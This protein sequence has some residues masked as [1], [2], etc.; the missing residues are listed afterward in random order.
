MVLDGVDPEVTSQRRSRAPRRLRRAELPT[1]TVALARYLIGKTLVEAGPEGRVSGRI[2]ET[3]AY[4]VGDAACHAFRGVTPR[5]RSLFLAR[6]H[7]YVY[8]I[9]GV[10]FMLNVSSETAGVGAGVLLR[11]VEPL[12]GAA[13]M[14]T[15]RRLPAATT[16]PRDLARGPGRL[17]QAFAI[18]R[19]YDGLDLCADGPL[20]LGSAAR[21]TGSL[22]TS[23]R[24]GLTIEAERVLRFYERANPCVSGPR[25]LNTQIV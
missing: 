23:V 1:G 5:N 6:G 10:S 18:D 15:R 12:E 7:A 25:R 8:F 22:G 3:E 20:W 14:A 21:P 16:R 17:A 24:I 11:A 4:L 19:R 9:Y 2:V 13:L